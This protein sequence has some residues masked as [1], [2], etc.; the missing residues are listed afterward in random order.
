MDIVHELSSA[1]NPRS[2]GHAECAIRE[3]KNLLKKTSNYKEFKVALTEWRNTPR[4][5]GLSPAQWLFG[6]RQRTATIAAPTAYERIDDKQLQYHTDLRGASQK[7]SHDKSAKELQPFEKGEKAQVQDLKTGH[8]LCDALV[9]DVRNG[10]CSYRIEL[11]GGGKQVCNRVQL[12]KKLDEDI[13]IDQAG[14]GIK[15]SMIK[16]NV[17]TVVN[18]PSLHRS[19]RKRRLN[20]KY[21]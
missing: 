1:Y 13:D 14:A 11:E 12:R 7:P 9:L 6:H 16:N 10:G 4:Y 3:V 2:N 17:S 5:D 18:M 21:N 15:E 19:K 8:W 20:P